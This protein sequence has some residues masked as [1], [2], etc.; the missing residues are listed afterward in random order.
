METL[1]E[2]TLN[3]IREKCSPDWVLG[4]FNGHVIVNLPNSGEE[5]RLAYKKAKKEITGCI[6]EYLPERNIDILIEV[7]S[8]SLNCSFKLAL[9]L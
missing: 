4:I 8:G 1:Q 3:I 9:T 5:P 7:R 2:S 6:K